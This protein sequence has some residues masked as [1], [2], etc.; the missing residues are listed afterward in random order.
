MPN[1]LQ[2]MGERRYA[3][4]EFENQL[5]SVVP[6]N[7]I[8]KENGALFC[9]WTASHQP[10]SSMEMPNPNWPVF[11]IVKILARRGLL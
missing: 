6:V 11:S 10:A 4:V 3:V 2:T 8:Y 5:V 9:H 7:W 1:L